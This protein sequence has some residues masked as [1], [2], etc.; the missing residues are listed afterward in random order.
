MVVSD[1]QI[2]HTSLVYEQHN[3]KFTL[4]A[5]VFCVHGYSF[6][7]YWPKNSVTTNLEIYNF[8]TRPGGKIHPCDV[9]MYK[10]YLSNRLHFLWV[11]RRWENA[12]K[13]CKSL[14]FES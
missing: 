7:L 2:S 10:G 5:W 12:R 14:A 8:L 13:A 1:E 3:L 11:Y 9:N 6:Q 4:C